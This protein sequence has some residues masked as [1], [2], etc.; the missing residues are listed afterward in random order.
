LRACHTSFRPPRTVP[1]SWEA[2]YDRTAA[3]FS[4][5]LVAVSE[6]INIQIFQDQPPITTDRFYA[7][8]S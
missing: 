7:A 5:K 4:M 6:R 3:D 8:T 2:I 1:G